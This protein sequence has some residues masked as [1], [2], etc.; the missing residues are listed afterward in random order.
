MCFSASLLHVNFSPSFQFLR[1][2]FLDM[3][4]DAVPKK[5]VQSTLVKRNA[6]KAV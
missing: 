6:K 5:L 4:L 3:S 2:Y 1:N